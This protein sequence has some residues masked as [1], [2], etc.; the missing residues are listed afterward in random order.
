MISGKL[1]SAVSIDIISEIKNYIIGNY[2]A[3]SFTPTVEKF[4]GEVQ[5]NRNVISD[6]GDV[7]QNLDS[8]KYNRKICM[9][10]IT[11]LNLLKSKMYFGKEKIAVHLNFL[12]KDTLKN[13]NCSSMNINFEL[14]NVMFNLANIYLNIAKMESVEAGTDDAKLK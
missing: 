6:L 11:Q 2:D 10:Y 4:L 3:A 12:W 8:L 5:Q 1:K 13:S 9:K 7:K 14:Y